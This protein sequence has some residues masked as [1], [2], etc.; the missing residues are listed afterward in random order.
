MDPNAALQEIGSLADEILST[1][2]H[3][4]HAQFATQLAERVQDLD[5]WLSKG[6]FLPEAWA[7]GR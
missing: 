6:G 2:D 4:V 3:E 5:G 1:T 7:V